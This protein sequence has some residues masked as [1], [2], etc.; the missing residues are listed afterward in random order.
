[1]V[2][3]ETFPYGVSDDLVDAATQFFDFV[4][5]TDFSPISRPWPVMG[6]LG[7]V[8]QARAALH[9]NAGRP[10]RYVFSRR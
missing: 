7:N 1:M 4:R 2:E 3:F 5:S 9:F 10:T 6:A 8:R